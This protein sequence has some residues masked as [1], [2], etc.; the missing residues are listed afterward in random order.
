MESEAGCAA[1]GG[2]GGG[3]GVGVVAWSAVEELGRS[4]PLSLRKSG[5]EPAKWWLTPTTLTFGKLR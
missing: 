2:G 5:L 1:G 3:V 4:K